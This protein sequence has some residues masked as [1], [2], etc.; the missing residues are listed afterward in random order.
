MDNKKEALCL[1]LKILKSDEK[2]FDNQ[3]LEFIKLEDML[4]KIKDS[5]LQVIDCWEEF[6]CIIKWKLIKKHLIFYDLH[7]FVHENNK[8]IYIEEVEFLEIKSLTI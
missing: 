4:W 1:K 8:L 2:R 6:N 3:I 5:E 7:T